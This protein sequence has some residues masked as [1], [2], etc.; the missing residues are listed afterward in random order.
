M[1]PSW[2]GFLQML[3]TFVNQVKKI[4]QEF[5]NG[6]KHPRDFYLM[7]EKLHAIGIAGI[8]PNDTEIK[9]PDGSVKRKANFRKDDGEVIPLTLVQITYE[10]EKAMTA[11]VTEEE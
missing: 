11:Y 7:W 9:L 6:K 4:V 2:Q 10:G 3:K 8:V 5:S 1:K